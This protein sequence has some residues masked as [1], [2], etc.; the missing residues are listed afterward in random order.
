MFDDETIA[1]YNVCVL[2]I[3]NES[4]A[5]GKRLFETKL[6]RKVLCSLPQHFNMKV[7]PIEEANDIAISKLD[8]ELLGSLITYEL[9]LSDSDNNK[10]K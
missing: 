9:N 2:D 7:T 5:L 8:D 4:F 1:E 6:V 10:S 3:G